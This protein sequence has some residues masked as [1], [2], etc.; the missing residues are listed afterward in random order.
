MKIPKI[1][2][3]PIPRATE[4][5]QTFEFFRKLLRNLNDRRHVA[6]SNR[7]WTKRAVF[8][9]CAAFIFVAALFSILNVREQ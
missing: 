2:A 3:T 1:S 5:P 8:P 7:A 4:K 9:A 6:H